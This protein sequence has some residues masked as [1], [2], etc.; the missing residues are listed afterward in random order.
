MAG[1]RPLEPSVEVRI[2]PGQQPKRLL[3][4]SRMTQ[5][6]SLSIFSGRSNPALARSIAKAYGQE[7]G[8]L[9]IKT[10]SD[11]EIYVH[12]EES[13]RGCDVFLIQS[14][15]PAADNWLELFLLIDAA[16]RASAGRITAVIPYFGYAR[17]ERKDQP[18]VSIA[19][20]L[21]AD[22]LTTA[23]VDRVLTMDLH[24]SQ[25]Q[26]FFDMPVDLLYGSAVFIDY[27]KKLDLDN[28][29]IVAPDVGSVKMARSYAKK[30][31][32][33]LAI[34]D[35]RRPAQNEVEVMNIIGEVAGKNVLLIDDMIDTAGTITNAAGALRKAGALEITAAGTHAI[36]SGPA[37]ERLEASAIS[38]LV[39]TDTVPLHRTLDKIQVVS[40]ADIFADAINRICTDES[41][42]T[43]FV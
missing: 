22:I 27:F 28:F 26:G 32:A 12:Y 8:K 24:A 37:F 39:V 30:L 29:V 11:G 15:Q 20:K 38:R 1:Q 19:A 25:I 14:T 42:S 9:E 33:D 10:F 41:I 6:K 40:V 13:I 17:Q 4:T 2:L 18:R 5:K 36:L 35:K 16:K 7:L 23:G 43:L 21:M 31:D 34:I 3:A